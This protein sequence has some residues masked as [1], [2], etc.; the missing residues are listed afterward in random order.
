MGGFT[1]NFSSGKYFCRYCKVTK[2]SFQVNPLSSGS[3]RTVAA[4]EDA[5]TRAFSSFEGHVEG[6][7]FSSVFN[8]L[9]FFH[10]ALPGLPPCL[11]HDVFEGVVEYDLPLYINYFVAHKWF[12]IRYI[13]YKLT[14][15]KFLLLNASSKPPLLPNNCKRLPGNASQNWCM[16]R[17]FSLLVYDKVKDYDN[18]V[19]CLYLK[20]REIVEIVCSPS[21][22]ICDTVYL[23]HLVEW[24]VEHRVKMFSN[25]P[26]RP[27]HHFLLHYPGLIV[28][29]G[30][31]I[32]AWT[33]RF[34]SKHSYFKNVVFSCGNSVNLTKTLSYY[35]QAFQS[36][37]LHSGLIDSDVT[38]DRISSQR[39]SSEML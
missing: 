9:K 11:G 26:L 17:F 3:L 13:N 16:L 33:M 23:K 4:Y 19:W 28:K 22:L 35:H 15:F 18:L 10:V 34:E 24:Y 25:V 20:L 7:K 31:L 39:Y 29:F 2:D 27:K 8:E 14:H 37:L 5:V 1:T 38:F 21:I 6:I 32:K 12:D 30:P 36:T